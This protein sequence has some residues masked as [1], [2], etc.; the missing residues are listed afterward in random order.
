[1]SWRRDEL[2][3]VTT[4][5]AF[6]KLTVDH[7]RPLVALVADDI[8]KRKPELVK[9]LA[10]VMTKPDKVQTLYGSLDSLAQ[11]AVQEAAHHP[12]GLL[13]RDKFIARHGQMPAFSHP[14]EKKQ[15]SFCDYDRHKRPTRLALFFPA[16]DL[17]P[18]DLR[19]ILIGF[20]PRPSAFT[21]PTV[22]ELPAAFPQPWKSNDRSGK[23]TADIPLC[24][25]ETSREAEHD[26]RAVLRLIEAGKVRVSD[27][28]RLPTAASQK[29]IGE[30]LQGGDFYSASDADKWK[31]DPAFDLTMRAFAWPILL[32]AAALAQQSGDNLSLTAA[33]RKALAGAAA[34]VIREI[35]R[36]WRST[37]FFD[38]FRRV[39]AIKGQ[40]KGGF[41]A[42]ASRR[43]TVLEALATS[44]IDA[45]FKVDDFFRFLRATDRDFD[46][47]HRPYDLYIAEHYYGNLGYDSKHA[48][49]QLQGRYIL[50]LLFEY[51][52]T[53][54][55][56]DVAY[57]PPQ[58]VRDDFRDRWGADD[59]SCLSRYDGLLYLRINPLGAW[60]L[61]ITDRH[62]TPKAAVADVLQVLPNLEIIVKKPPL[63][64][65]DRL[66][67][68]R[69]CEPQS[70]GVWKLTPSKLL[71]VLEE[72]GTLDELDEFLKS[73]SSGPLPQTVEVLLEDQRERAGQ[74]LDLG[75]AR[76]I[77]CR[78]PTLAR[79]LASDPQLRGKCHLAGDRWLVFRTEDEAAVRRALRRLGHIVPPPRG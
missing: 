74:L 32:Q 25:R 35:F 6:G 41:S 30:V 12:K 9:V 22:A 28:K 49:E 68:E 75:M 60:C 76:F 79:M 8:P 1:M 5:E 26:L 29:A 2:V 17:L 4:E 34:D 65:S 27:K 55:L 47:S 63:P 44:P 20:V 38:E 78:D 23:E 7:L 10:G 64:A 51:V 66:V 56:V 37:N 3:P 21:L 77:E 40:D 43:K 73:H 46:L 50:A 70:E 71:A 33:G 36:K 57:V 58:G 11:H 48:W 52:A 18:S 62:E 31:H 45:W 69:F 72:G 42:L 59:L 13:H 67:L 15:S 39:E 24:I 53:L 61:G 16:N 54:G 14:S 19:T